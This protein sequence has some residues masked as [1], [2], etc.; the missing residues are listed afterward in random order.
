MEMNNIL[1]HELAIQF[2]KEVNEI[3]KLTFEFGVK[4]GN[5]VGAVHLTTCNIFQISGISL[6][7]PEFR[8]LISK[9]IE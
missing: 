8:K 6:N 7:L 1:D 9:D 5:C 3:K 2:Q 4:W